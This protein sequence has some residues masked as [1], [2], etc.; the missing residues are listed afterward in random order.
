MKVR[1]RFSKYGALRFIGHLDV[2]RYFQKAI[3]RCDIAIAYSEG[4]SPHQVMSFAAPLSVGHTSQG[5]Y[6]D[7]EVTSFPGKE[8]L[9]KQLQAVMVEGI[10]ILDVQL[11]P[12]GEKNAMASVAAASYLVAFRQSAQLPCGWQEKLLAFYEQETIPVLKKTKKSEK[13]I[14]LK[15]SIYQLEI[16]KAKSS[17]AFLDREE[18]LGDEVYLLLNASSGE[19]IKPGFVLE[20]FFKTLGYE[21][22]PFALMIHRL[23]TY[24]DIGNQQR[25]PGCD[26][27]PHAERKLVPLIWEK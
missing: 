16:R 12:E 11:L 15:D 2:M 8:E 10:S 23:E 1:I 21:L 9:E 25:M 13:Q 24:K 3:R 26:G 6:L 20:S 7:I 19:N 22:P 14:N 5:E 18:T 4:F 17:D 27:Q